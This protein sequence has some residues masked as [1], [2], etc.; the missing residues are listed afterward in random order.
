MYSF[1]FEQVGSLRNG[2]IESIC[3]LVLRGLELMWED[4]YM[5]AQSLKPRPH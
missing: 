5:A 4:R 2:F 1:Q 3:H